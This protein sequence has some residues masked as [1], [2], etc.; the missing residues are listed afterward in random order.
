MISRDDKQKECIKYW[1]KNKACGTMVMPTGFGKTRTA[2]KALKLFIDKRKDTTFIVVVPTDNLKVQW[3]QQLDEWGL[4]LNGQV[5]IINTAIKNK[6]ITDILVI[7]ECHRS[8]STCFR[9]LFKAVQYKYVLGLTATYERLDGLQRE[10]MDK[11]CPVCITVTLEEALLNEW[12]SP[13]TEYQV[14]ISVDDIDEYK[15]YNKEFVTHFEFF[16]FDW[17]KVM[18]CIGPKGF[19][20]RSKLRDEMCPNGTEEQRKQMFQ[21]ITFHATG[22]MRALTK[23]KAFINNHPKKLELARKIINA[24]PNSKIITFSNNIKMAESIGIGPVYSGK[25]S[26]KKARASLEEFNNQEKG[27]LNSIKKLCEGADL[28]GLDTAIMLGIDSSEIRATQSRGRAIRFKQGKHALIFNLII[29]D[30]VE[31]TWFKNSHKNSQYVTIDENGLD[32]VLNNKE[33]QP[34]KKTIKQ[35]Q[36]RF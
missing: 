18:S 24:L 12:L 25:D 2:L 4:S 29:D 36:F 6:Y 27:V 5:I 19:I 22:F 1:L 17:N 11:Y 33:P 14:L 26:K 32:D 9:E 13:Y 28:K 16:S 35:F 31:T 7:D 3:E 20:A 21:Q 23:R 10:V 30:T 15:K 34:Y 8:N